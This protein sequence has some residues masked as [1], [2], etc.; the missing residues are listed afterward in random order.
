MVS[1][2]PRETLSRV[3][4]VAPADDAAW[5]AV[6]GLTPAVAAYP[7]SVA[8]VSALVRE[9]AAEGWTVLP[10]GGGT[11]LELGARPRA[12]DVALC[13]TDLNRVVEYE[14]A[15]LVVTVEAGMRSGE[16]QRILGEHGQFLALDPPLAHQATI[17]GILAANASGPLRLRYGTA[18]DLLLGVKVVNADGAVT[19]SGG[20]VVKNVTGYDMGKLYTG[21]LGTLGI[22]VEASFKLA[23]LP[24]REATVLAFFQDCTAAFSAART[25]HKSALPLRACE[26][27]SRATRLGDGYTLA[28]WLGGGEASVERQVR[29]VM[30]ACEVAQVRLLEGDEQRA[31]WRGIEDFGRARGFPV[32]AK[33]STRPASTGEFL[34]QLPKDAVWLSHVLSGVTYLFANEPPVRAGLAGYVVLE[35]CPVDLKSPEVVWGLP[36]PDYTLMERLKRQFDPRGIFNPGRYVGGL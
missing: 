3:C 16:L 20:R 32:I 30:G 26:L 36:G 1:D 11:Q 4:H 15:D 33:V 6:D 8:E 14:P 2:R 12:F 31:V 10:R 24:Q 29:A 28:V 7:S 18:R 34:C 19:K 21:S 23:P 25:L 13:L 9:A 17:G 5:Y 22:I 27:L 35:R